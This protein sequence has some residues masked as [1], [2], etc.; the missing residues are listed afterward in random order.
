M[1]FAG[2]P[3]YGI[4]SVLEGESGPESGRREH[5]QPQIRRVLPPGRQG[6]LKIPKLRE[7]DLS[8]GALWKACG[9]SLHFTT[10]F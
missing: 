7:A 10:A 1:K 4:H 3:V 5:D 9:R 2:P 6:I 8:G